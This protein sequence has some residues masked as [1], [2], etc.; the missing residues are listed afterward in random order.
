MVTIALKVL[1]RDYHVF[2]SSLGGRATP[3][4]FIELTRILLQEEQRM[5]VFEMDSHTLDLALMDKEKKP[6]KGK[7]WDRNSIGKFQPRN[8]GMTHSKYGSHDKRNDGCFYY[9]KP[10]DHAKYCYKRKANESKQMPRKHNGNYV[11]ADT[12]FSEGFKNL[13]LFISEAALSIETD[14]ENAWFIDSG[15]LAHVLRR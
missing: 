9:G 7:P 8:I 12:S 14:D 11:K 10:G 4:T 2:I 15:A 3:P 13:K 5:K 1:I 6:Y